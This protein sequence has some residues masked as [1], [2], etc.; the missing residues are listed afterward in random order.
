[1]TDT[2]SDLAIGEKGE[3]Q[4]FILDNEN[5]PYISKLT[6]LGFVAGGVVQLIDTAPMG[7]PMKVRLRDSYF[8]LRKKEVSCIIIKKIK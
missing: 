7:D 4:E 8:A 5:I 6:N 2:L 3:I 1:M